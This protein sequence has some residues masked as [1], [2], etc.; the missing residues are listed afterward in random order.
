M[1]L[2]EVLAAT[3]LLILGLSTFLAAFSSIQRLSVAS[4]NR[5]KALHRAREILEAVM[6]QPYDS[7]SLNTGTHNLPDAQYTV[8]MTTEF[9][10][11]KDIKVSVPWVTPIGNQTYQIE[12]SGSMA[13]CIHQ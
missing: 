6:S 1:T 7:H 9:V 8:S 5:N 10:T 4:D 3:L 12:L 13:Q 11:T 2:I